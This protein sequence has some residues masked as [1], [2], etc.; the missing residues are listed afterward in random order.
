MDNPY[1]G[2]E[3]D[4][5]DDDYKL[6]NDNFQDLLRNCKWHLSLLFLLL[7]FVICN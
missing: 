5:D 2:E 6:F 7:S 4:D 1:D 3:E